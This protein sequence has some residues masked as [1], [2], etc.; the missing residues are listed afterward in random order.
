MIDSDPWSYPDNHIEISPAIAIAVPRLLEIYPE[1]ILVHLV[2]RREDCVASIAR[3]LS[4]DGR[5]FINYWG[6]LYTGKRYPEAG[7]R[8]IAA[9]LYDSTVALVRSCRPALEIQLEAAAET[10]PTF[11]DLVGADGDY[12]AGLA[13][14]SIRHNTRP[15]G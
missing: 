4:E 11:W 12:Q 6:N 15:K 10:W 5:H 13:A 14:W 1:A 2:R 3:L 7:R 9:Y 8:R